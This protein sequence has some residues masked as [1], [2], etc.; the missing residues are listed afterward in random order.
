MAI[1]T[2]TFI[3]RDLHLLFIAA[4]IISFLQ[5]GVH[6]TGAEFSQL[7]AIAEN[8]EQR[9]RSGQ[10]IMSRPLAEGELFAATGIGLQRVPEF[11]AD[12]LRKSGR[13]LTGL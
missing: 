10:N 12:F 4:R 11:D 8:K 6:R 9:T 5:G 7:F 3:R 13:S 1:A 2:D